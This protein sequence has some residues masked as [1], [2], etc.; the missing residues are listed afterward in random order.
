MQT[1][2]LKI[3]PINWL[4]FIDYFDHWNKNKSDSCQRYL[5]LIYA[6]EQTYPYILCSYILS[7]NIIT[8]KQSRI[9]IV[10]EKNVGHVESFEW[11]RKKRNLFADRIKQ[12]GFEFNYSRIHCISTDVGENLRLPRPEWMGF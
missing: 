8:S 4:L 7:I 6:F 5:T 9:Y 11:N 2:H 3:S 12:I 10:I 1:I